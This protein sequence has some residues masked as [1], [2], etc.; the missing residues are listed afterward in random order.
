MLSIFK[1]VESLQQDTKLYRLTLLNLNMCYI[2]L[3]INH[4]KCL[5]VEF[6]TKEFPIVVNELSL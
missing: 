2:S 1:A 5:Y 6:D 4:K 3:I